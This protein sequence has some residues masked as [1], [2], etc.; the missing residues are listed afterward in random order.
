MDEH[1]RARGTRWIAVVVGA[2]AGL[3][4]AGALRAWMAE[5]AG[6]ESQFSWGTFVGVLLPGLLVGAA[7]GWASS[8]GSSPT[9]AERRLL[10]WCAAAPLAFAIAPLLRP[11]AVAELF[12]NGLGGGAVYVA[13]AAI[14]GGYALGGR[15]TWA[16][17]VCGVLALGSALAGAL[18]AGP[19]VRGPM[20]ALDTPRGAWLAVLDLALLLVLYAAASI[21]FRRLAASA[22]AEGAGRVKTAETTDVPAARAAG[23]SADSTR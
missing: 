5:L 9:K 8:V 14:A 22:H 13:L 16:R 12:T 3:A 6:Y 1:G 15:R 4:W 17:I 23:T 20:L 10:R 19:M 11:G 21:P 2:V 18:L 7:F